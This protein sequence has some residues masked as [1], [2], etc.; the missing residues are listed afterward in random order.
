MIQNISHKVTK[1]ESYLNDNKQDGVLKEDGEVFDSMLL[2]PPA[3]YEC[4]M[5]YTV[6]APLNEGCTEQCPLATSR[7]M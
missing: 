2:T 3:R 6:V 5:H 1:R 4:R 7:Q